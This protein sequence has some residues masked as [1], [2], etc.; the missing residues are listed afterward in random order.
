MNIVKYE[1]LSLYLW[2]TL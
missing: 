1:V 2:L